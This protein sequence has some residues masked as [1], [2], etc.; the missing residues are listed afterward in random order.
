LSKTWL[1]WLASNTWRWAA[2]VVTSVVV[3]VGVALWG[4]YG[5][6]SR[7]GSIASDFALGVVFALAI[8]LP[9][10]LVGFL[11]YVIVVAL[12]VRRMPRRAQ[13]AV[14]VALSPVIGIPLWI[15]LATYPYLP[16]RLFWHSSAVAVIL[17]GL[18]CRTPPPLL[19]PGGRS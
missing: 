2:A 12:V 18:A 15:P 5:P 19:G 17:T 14:M 6:P 3:F 11:F 8:V 4:L 13:R 9:V 1:S 7:Q 16:N 10:L